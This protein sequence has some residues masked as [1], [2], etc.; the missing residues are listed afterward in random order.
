MKYQGIPYEGVNNRTGSVLLTL[1][2][3]CVITI[4]STSSC[5]NPGRLGQVI[6]PIPLEVPYDFIDKP[7]IKLSDLVRSPEQR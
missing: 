6:N 2:G 7:K 4:V 5:P 1:V 3:T